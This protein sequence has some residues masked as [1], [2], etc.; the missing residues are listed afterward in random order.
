[1]QVHSMSMQELILKRDKKLLIKNKSE[2]EN[3]LKEETKNY[4]FFQNKSK[5]LEQIIQEEKG[6]KEL[7]EVKEM[8]KREQEDRKKSYYEM[9]KE[10]HPPVLHSLSL[11]IR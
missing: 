4:K 11:L 10:L 5:F 9:V 7:I 1:M 3:K 6:K 8:E 2:I